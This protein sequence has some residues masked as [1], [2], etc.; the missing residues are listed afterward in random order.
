MTA[1][2]RCAAM[3]DG[4]HHLE[5]LEMDSFSMTVDKVVARGAKDVGHL[6]GGPGHCFCFLLLDR[7]TASRLETA[8]VSTGLVTACR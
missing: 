4:V 2:S 6:H 7:F 8:M 5:L 3:L 1:E